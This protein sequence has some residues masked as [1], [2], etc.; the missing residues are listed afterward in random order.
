MPKITFQ[1]MGVTQEVES[2]T[3]VLAAAGE[4]GVFLR[5]TCGGKAMCATC[6]SR[7]LEGAA[8]L[9]PMARHE[10]KRLK[11]LYAPKEV[12]LSCQAQILGDVT[13]EV[14]VPKL[15]L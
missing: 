15:G 11:E 7:V 12:R 1:P 13:V 14:P 6:R 4:A 9:S 2:G 5:H 10:Q 8:N 3:T